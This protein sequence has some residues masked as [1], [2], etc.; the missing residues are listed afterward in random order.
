ML[1][2]GN[3]RLL[4]ERC[5]SAPCFFPFVRTVHGYMALVGWL[6]GGLGVKVLVAVL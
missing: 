6:V 3:A 1:S 5:A 2:D 4:K